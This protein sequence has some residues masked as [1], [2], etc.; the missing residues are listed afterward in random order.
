[1]SKSYQLRTECRYIIPAVTAPRDDW[2]RLD[3]EV[4]RIVRRNA[5]RLRP[6]PDPSVSA[7][8][9]RY[10]RSY[11]DAPQRA[12]ERRLGLIAFAVVLLIVILTTMALSWASSGPAWCNVG[13]VGKPVIVVS[14]FTAVAVIL[15]PFSVFKGRTSRLV[16]IEAVNKLALG[17]SLV[18]DE[19]D[20]E[21]G[22]APAV[23]GFEPSASASLAVRYEPRRV[24]RAVVRLLVPMCL[25]VALAVVWWT[26]G[27]LAGLSH[28]VA[29]LA[30]C[31][32]VIAF[33]VLVL[34]FACAVLVRAALTRRLLLALD[35]DGL[36][37][38]D[39]ACTLPWAEL[40]EVRLISTRYGRRNG[41]PAVIL[42]FVP[43]DP[44]G[45]LS[46][47]RSTGRRRQRLEKSLQ[48][49]GTPLAIVDHLADHAAAE[50][51]TAVG[52]F[53]PVAVRRY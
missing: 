21:V 28:D 5:R 44:A 3:P 24:M 1:M 26:S 49:H 48:V 47:I 11:L 42:A 46:S 8:A 10:A 36:H 2:Q 14:G 12:R 35:A 52:A 27:G 29:L 17:G 34:A 50:I 7:V 45:V 33:P 39:I 20:D 19:A 38:P 37:L 53:T 9:A 30:F 32:A 23:A 15:F 43:R 16:R 40:A 41:K 6:H 18:D 13:A 25:V 51:A 31:T 22:A 4:R